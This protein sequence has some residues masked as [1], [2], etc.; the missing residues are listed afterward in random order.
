M[1]NLRPLR[2]LNKANISIQGSE[3][4]YSIPRAYLDNLE[5]YKALEI[6]LFTKDNKWIDPHKSTIMESYP[7]LQELLE[8]YEEGTNP[9]GYYVPLHL[10]MSLIKW[11]NKGE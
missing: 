11:L 3:H 9:V 7:D 5:D 2:K 4:H 8:H 1:H 6:A 10:V